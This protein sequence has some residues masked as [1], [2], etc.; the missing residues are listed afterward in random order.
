[1][2]LFPHERITRPD[3]V[4]EHVRVN[5]PSRPRPADG[6]DVGTG[7]DG[8]RPPARPPA[9]HPGPPEPPAPTPPASREAAP[10]S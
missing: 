6:R 4:R 8:P 5:E 10:A 7:T 2:V 9:A 1:M 3:V